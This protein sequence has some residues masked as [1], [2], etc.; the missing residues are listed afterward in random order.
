MYNRGSILVIFIASL[1]DFYKICISKYEYD[2]YGPSIVHR[3]F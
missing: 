2:E 3:K 1:S